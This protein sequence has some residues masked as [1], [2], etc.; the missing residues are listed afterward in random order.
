MIGEYCRYS[1]DYDFA[2]ELYDTLI[3]PA[4]NFMSEFIDAETQLPHA[5]YDLWEEKFLTSTYSTAV[6]YRALLVA[7]HFADKFG[8][9]DDHLKWNRVSRTILD[10]ANVFYDDSLG[11][12]V[13]G[14]LLNDKKELD[15]DT[16]LDISSFYGVTTF[17]L[18][19]HSDIKKVVST[20]KKI[21]SELLDVSPSGG[22]SRYSDDNYFRS[23]PP[24]RGNP[25]IVTTLWMAQFYVHVKKHRKAKHYID[26]AISKSLPSG[27][28][29]EQI[30]PETSKPTSVAPLI[31]SHAELIN[32][33]LDYSSIK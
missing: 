5:S 18:L 28:L 7:A 15:Y 31:W 6:T 1:R 22:T 13:K 27:V 8:H 33:I 4:A 12:Y 3:R 19:K 16:T 24:Y 32:S 26:W 11:Y 10:K 25:W 14:Y 2:S 9:H 29:S 23:D 20:A 21:E 17:G 30:N